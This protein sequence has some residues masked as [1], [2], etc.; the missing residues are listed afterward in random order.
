MV[1]KDQPF[2]GRIGWARRGSKVHLN[3]VCQRLP[4]ILLLLP[5]RPCW[6]GHYGRLCFFVGGTFW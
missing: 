5:T 6:N 2:D 3:E 1:K 4:L